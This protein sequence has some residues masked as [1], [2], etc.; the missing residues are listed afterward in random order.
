[1]ANETGQE[2][3]VVTYDLGV[4]LKAY[5]IEALNSLLFD[6]LLIML[7]NFHL[8]MAFYGAIGT[9]INESGAEYLLTECGILAEGSLIG[10]T[11]GKY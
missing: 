3:G 11:Q 2:Y 4:A 5:S 10:F 6:K 9:F 7:G 1:M 8:E